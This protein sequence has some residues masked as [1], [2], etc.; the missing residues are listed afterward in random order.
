[1]RE[2]RVN[3]LPTLTYR[4]L[5]TN[6]TPFMFKTPE[7]IANAVFSEN[8]YLKKEF[9]FPET[10]KGACEETIKTALEGHTYTI[11]IPENVKTKLIIEINTSEELKDFSGAF[12]VILE[13]SSELELVWKYKGEKNIATILT[14]VQYDVGK[15]AE[16]K[17]S[18]IQDG[19]EDASIYD[20]RNII[21]A[22]NAHAEF[23]AA[24]FG[25]KEVIV[26]SYAQLIGNNS[27]LFESAVY[28]AS[29]NQ[30]VDFFYHI[31]CIG[32][33]TDG[34]IDVKGAL[35]DYSKKVFR[36]ILN[37]INGCS[38]S[39]GDES[40]IAIQLDPTAR[41]VSLP[42][43]LCTED[44]V[45][46]NHASSAGQLDNNVLYFFMTRG[47]TKTEARHIIVESLICPLIDK[48]DESIRGEVMNI[49]KI[50]LE[51]REENCE[52]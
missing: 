26:H 44:D 11:K 23:V 21:M 3:R 10:Y 13:E 8:K 35:S 36:G 12:H 9:N 51:S 31:D 17:V 28:M 33:N 18:R 30:K 42:L 45:Q 29:G 50:Q 20:E 27:S 38:G 2:I 4:Y 37:F 48:M 5:K 7:N 22:E 1:M 32:K 47:F 19:F 39:V 25:G 14:A 24:E 40:D 16:L 49:V 46:G 41:N 34:N 6:D 15:N 43:L 52:Q